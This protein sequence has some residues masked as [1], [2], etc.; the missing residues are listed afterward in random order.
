M[1]MVKTIG[2]DIDGVLYDF[3][4]AIYDHL[5]MYHNLSEN[6]VDFWKAERNGRGGFSYMFW[7]SIIK[8][9]ILYEQYV[10]H[11]QD[12]QTL[13][14]LAKRFNFIYVTHRPEDVRFVTKYWF[15]ENELP[16]RDNIY[17]SKDKSLPIIEHQCLYF[18][19]DM[20]RNVKDLEGLTN[21]ILMKKA[22]HTE[23]DLEL[24]YISSL[25]ELEELL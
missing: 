9:P 15:K 10:I 13:D 17:F 24:T 7:D 16:Y 18:V 4:T 8:L 2:F 5:K 11:E 23:E 21:A 3:H 14:K 1:G 12:R 20:V 25:Q 6:Y 22:W 19:D